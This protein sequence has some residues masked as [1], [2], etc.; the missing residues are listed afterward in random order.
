MGLPLPW[1]KQHFLTASYTWYVY[2]LCAVCTV[3]QMFIKDHYAN[4]GINIMYIAFLLLMT[5]CY[6]YA[7]FGPITTGMVIS[8]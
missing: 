8:K 1:I 3:K 2:A 4:T 6:V 7:L 5:V